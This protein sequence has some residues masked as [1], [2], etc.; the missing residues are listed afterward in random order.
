MRSSACF[1]L[2]GRQLAAA[3]QVHPADDGIERRAQL[4][5]QRG[6]ELVLQSIGL[7]LAIEQVGALAL[8]GLD[9][10]EHAD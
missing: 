3:Q 1:D 9:L 7:L 2:L 8:R 5:R 10:V 4:V 6:E